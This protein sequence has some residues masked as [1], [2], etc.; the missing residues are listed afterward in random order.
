MFVKLPESSIGMNNSP[1][2]SAST[3][4]QRETHTA[5]L[6][7]MES[8]FRWNN[9]IEGILNTLSSLITY[10]DEYLKAKWEWEFMRGCHK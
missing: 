10:S 2:N 3:T 5:F 7:W 6:G 4:Y 9:G 1:D 8:G